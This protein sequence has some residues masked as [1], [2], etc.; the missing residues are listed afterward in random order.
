MSSYVAGVQDD[1]RTFGHNKKVNGHSLWAMCLAVM[2]SIKKALSIVPK[3]SPWIIMIDKNCAVIDYASGKNEHLFMQ[4]VDKGMFAITKID[5]D[6]ALIVDGNEE[7][8]TTTRLSE[9][10]QRHRS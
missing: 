6:E 4:L 2:C 3:L 7:W 8:T 1:I 5:G 9:L 10:C